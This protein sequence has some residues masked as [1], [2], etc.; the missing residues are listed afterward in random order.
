MSIIPGIHAQ[1]NIDLPPPYYVS[2]WM[3]SGESISDG[4]LTPSASRPS[5]E[6]KIKVSGDGA[7]VHGVIRDQSGDPVA[8]TLAIIAP[9]P[10]RFIDGFPV[11]R[12]ANATSGEFTFS[13]LAPGEY[14]L[15]AIEEFAWEE[16][17][18]PGLL[19]AQLRD[20]TPVIAKAGSETKSETEVRRIAVQ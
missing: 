1:L 11:C 10:M 14:R 3:Y 9:W 18:R 12:T 8:N 2:S 13:Q 7:T 15:L 19:E 5:Q 16:W 17:Q 4:V 6:I 20:A